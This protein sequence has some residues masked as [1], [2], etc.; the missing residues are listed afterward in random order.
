[1]GRLAAEMILG[2]DTFVDPN[3]FAPNRFGIIDPFT[4]EFQKRCANARSNK[5][6]G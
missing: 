6:G 3:L 2:E 5:K 4:A 1:M